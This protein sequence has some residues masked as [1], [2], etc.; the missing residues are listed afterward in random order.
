MAADSTILREYLVALGFQVNQTEAKKFDDGLVK[1]DKRANQLAIGLV[2]VGTAA[3]AMVARFAYSMEKLYFASKR[4]DSAV[5]SIQALE[6]GASKIGVSGD[7]IRGSLEAMARNIRSNP[8]LTGLLNSLGVKVEGRDKS[9]VLTDL[10]GQLKKMPSFVAEKYA[11]LFGIDPDTLFMLKEGLDEM[12]A[13]AAQR[14]QWAAESGV[15]SEKAAEASH[16][17]A[18]QWR[19]INERAGIFKD[20]LIIEMLPTLVEMGRVTQMLL[21]DWTSL[22]QQGDLW[23]R[24]LEGAGIKSTGGGVQL[25]RES[26]ARTGQEGDPD[27]GK[28]WLTRKYEGAMRAMGAKKYQRAPAG[29]GAADEASV[30]AAQDDSAFK[31]G[32]TG[33]TSSPSYVPNGRGGYTYQPPAASAPTGAP[34]AA[35]GKAPAGSTAGSPES[36]ALLRMLEKKYGLPEGQLDRIWAAESNRGD[37]KFMTSPVGAKGHFGIMDPT[38]KDLGLDKDGGRGD[39]DD[40]AKSADAAARYYSMLLKRY[41]GDD[42]KAAAA[43]NWGMGNVDKKGLA[44]APKETRDYM[45]KVAARGEGGGAQ[46]TQ[47]NNVTISGVSEPKRAAELTREQIDQSN[48]EVVRNLNSARVN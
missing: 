17:L 42:R 3:T 46:V 18:N 13:A 39:R 14:K 34:G 15:D 31:K 11:N 1:W 8:G 21:K 19:D 32:G 25:S 30:D 48:A 6:F 7:K 41:G 38:A 20:A 44:S 12:K 5:G 22:V 24:F 29:T 28:S 45:D 40:L 4:T 2:G 36:Q 9:D 37:K 23:S 10:V 33:R 47:T 35:A 26:L 43:Y 16:E 27:A